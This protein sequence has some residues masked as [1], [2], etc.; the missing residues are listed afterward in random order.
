MPMQ[1]ADRMFRSCLFLDFSCFEMFASL[2]ANAF[3]LG[4]LLIATLAVALAGGFVFKFLYDNFSANLFISNVVSFS[5]KYF[6]LFG[7]GLLLTFP[8]AM[9]FQMPADVP[10]LI[11]VGYIAFALVF[12]YSA[13]K[14]GR[15]AEFWKIVRYQKRYK[16][17]ARSTL[18]P[19]R[20]RS[21]TCRCAACGSKSASP[22]YAPI[23]MPSPAR[24]SPTSLATANHFFL[25]D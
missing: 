19:S 20:S 15:V 7:L 4:I 25:G 18:K 14:D 9:D 22:P 5:K 21:N 1:P 6:L 11:A 23:G 17:N 8:M 13:L 2:S 3:Y 12:G 24:I 16:P 10:R